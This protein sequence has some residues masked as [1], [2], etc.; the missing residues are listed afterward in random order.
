VGLRQARLRARVLGYLL[1]C[2]SVFSLVVVEGVDIGSTPIVDGDFLGLMLL[3][4][5]S[6]VI[7]YLL[8]SFN[9]TLRSFEK[10][11]VSIAMSLGILWWFV[12]GLN[13]INVHVPRE[14]S[15]AA[16]VLFA[17]LTAIGLVL[18]SKK[19]DW[20]LLGNSVFA[21]LPFVSLLSLVMCLD[22]SAAHSS[23]GLLATKWHPP[24]LSQSISAPIIMLMSLIYFHALQKNKIGRRYIKVCGTTRK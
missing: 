14:R 12:A 2:A 11:I 3:A 8:H 23:Q 17:T 1:H 15:F 22:R 9:A 16:S 7:A 10:V 19:L 21:M 20:K 24:N 18:T 4:I 5:S 6:V 13:E